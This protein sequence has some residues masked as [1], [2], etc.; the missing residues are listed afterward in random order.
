MEGIPTTSNDQW[1]GSPYT[2][3]IDRIWS[4]GPTASLWSLVSTLG[5]SYA[6]D[7]LP[8]G[9]DVP[10]VAPSDAR[11]VPVTSPR[12]LRSSVFRLRC[13]GLEERRF[14][15]REPGARCLGSTCS[16]NVG[17][18]LG[19]SVAA[20]SPSAGAAVRGDPDGLEGRTDLRVGTSEK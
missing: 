2:I 11:H 20:A 17:A 3:N 12:V 4:L 16:A 10:K 13:R 5:A 6:W 15:V 14:R 9:Q 19:R 8:K 1:N 18:G 7:Q